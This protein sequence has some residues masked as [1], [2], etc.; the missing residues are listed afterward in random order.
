MFLYKQNKQPTRILHLGEIWQI[1]RSG[2]KQVT[3]TTIHNQ[4]CKLDISGDMAP[5]LADYV[6]TIQLGAYLRS[7]GEAE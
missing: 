7:T 2:S 3:V 4:S 6:R 5:L 1:T